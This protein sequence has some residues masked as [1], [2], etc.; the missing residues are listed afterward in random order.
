M[1]MAGLSTALHPLSM[2]M[3]SQAGGETSKNAPGTVIYGIMRKSPIT[4]FTQT[5]INGIP[6]GIG[7]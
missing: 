2:F 5:G 1:I 7:R 3:Y 6:T 4:D